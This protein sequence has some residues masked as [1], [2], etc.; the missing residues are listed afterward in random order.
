RTLALS[1]LAGMPVLVLYEDKNSAEQN[2]AFKRELSELAKDGAYKRSIALVAVADVGAY[3]YWPIRGFVKSAIRD[4]S[5]KFKTVIYCD[6]NGE[7]RGALSV[8]PGVSNVVL[9]GKDGKAL[10]AHE[11]AMAP[12]T[13]K[14][15]V[16][17]LK[18]QID[19]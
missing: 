6:W 18:S 15:L 14:A 2:L 17:L 8:R 4:E 10:F 1:S 3:D 9:Y 11:G 7:A 12:E 19:K 13:R 16:D 5:A